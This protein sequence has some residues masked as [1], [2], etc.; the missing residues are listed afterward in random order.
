MRQATPGEY[1]EF[2]DIRKVYGRKEVLSGVSVTIRE[3]ELLSLLGPSGCGKTTL[4]RILAGFATPTQGEVRVGGKL[5]N[6]IP[7]NKR[8]VGMVFQ[9]YCLFPHLTVYDNVTFGLKM[10]GVDRAAMNK[11]A[12]EY[13]DLVHLADQKNRYP[14]QLSGGMKQR[15]ALARVLA[16][17]PNV[18]L[19]D[20]PF[21]ALDRN[22]KDEM[23]FE[24]RKLQ[25][26]LKITT[27]FVTHDQKEAMT[28]S[29]R[30]AVMNYGRI[31]HEGRP[32][33]IY[34]HPR[35]KFVAE[36]LGVPHFFSGRV[37]GW[38]G[39]QA[40]V[41][42]LDGKVLGIPVRERPSSPDVWVAVR[43]ERIQ[44]GAWNENKRTRA[45][46]EADA[47][48]ILPGVVV[49]T[50]NAGHIITYEVK[51]P[52]GTKLLVESPR[53]DLTAGFQPGDQVEVA[54]PGQNCILIE[55]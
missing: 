13:L 52:D 40:T 45:A 41:E 18:L 36:F 42:L 4:L 14:G 34:D 22:L 38:D 28:I 5:L 55:R 10:R 20:E 37:K 51:I 48:L 43:A 53:R 12:M 30:I 1:V 7:P 2:T 3:G 19:L 15:V 8:N 25:Q 29:D 54:I 39:G 32:L 23:Q 17:Q 46:G 49:F 50:T 16:F 6:P 31:E 27:L 33:E 35:T 21:A 9:H 11:R 26:L 24:V 44:L 47:D